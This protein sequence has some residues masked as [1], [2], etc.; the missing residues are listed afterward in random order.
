M[1]RI[2]YET[3]QGTVIVLVGTTDLTEAQRLAK[4]S[5]EGYQKMMD[6]E[7]LTGQVWRV[8]YD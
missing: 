2:A 1:I 5:D 7:R 6:Y 8:G 4:A 3:A